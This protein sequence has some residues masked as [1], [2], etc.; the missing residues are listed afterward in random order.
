MDQLPIER[1]GSVDRHRE[2]RLSV[3]DAIIFGCSGGSFWQQEL[4]Y[5]MGGGRSRRWRQDEDFCGTGGG[6]S[7]AVPP[8]H[9]SRP[10]TRREGAGIVNVRV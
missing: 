5:R 6:R 4:G 1:A 3:Y 7:L 2:Q 9:S 10:F 8:G